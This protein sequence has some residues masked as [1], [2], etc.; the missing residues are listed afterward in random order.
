MS[1][2]P[3]YDVKQELGMVYQRSPYQTCKKN[4][5]TENLR[6]VPRVEH[7]PSK[8]PITTTDYYVITCRKSVT[9]Q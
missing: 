3:Y 7:L 5:Q 6:L 1:P 8:P 2:W 4:R 9:I